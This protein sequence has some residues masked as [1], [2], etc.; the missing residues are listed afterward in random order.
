MADSNVD[1]SNP[2]GNVVVVSAHDVRVVDGDTVEVAGEKLRL[3]GWDTPEKFGN[4]QCAREK[5]LGE[6]ASQYA[7]TL[8]GRS[9]EFSFVRTGTDSYG[10]TLSHWSVD[11]KEYGQQLQDAGL[12]RRWRFGLELKPDWCLN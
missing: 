10:R 9:R 1:W 7:K 12:A 5:V 2:P 6:R 8:L 3:K 11:G 4:E